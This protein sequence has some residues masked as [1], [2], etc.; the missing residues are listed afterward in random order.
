MRL[1]WEYNNT[2]DGRVSGP[3]NVVVDTTIDSVDRDNISYTASSSVT[4]V[5]GAVALRMVTRV[6]V[7]LAQVTVE[8]VGNP[9]SLIGFQCKDG[10]NCIAWSVVSYF[11]DNPNAV[12][13]TGGMEQH[14]N[15]D[16]DATTFERVY[17][18]LC[19][20]TGCAG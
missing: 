9:A 20:L 7:S 3:V 12:A 11:N 15:L 14:S 8:R 19:T 1:H 4:R 18:A 2:T 13:P 10:S 5:G 16:T 17:A 6:R